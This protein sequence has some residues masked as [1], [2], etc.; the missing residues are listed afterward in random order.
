MDLS[1]TETSEKV[2]FQ[3]ISEN[4]ENSENME[5]AML[6]EGPVCMNRKQS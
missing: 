5:K 6:A 3:P 2:A 4:K 1:S